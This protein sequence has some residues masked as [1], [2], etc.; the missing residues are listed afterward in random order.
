MSFFPTV[1]KL[2]GSSI[3]K[4]SF[5]AASIRGLMFLRPS[6]GKQG[7]LKIKFYIDLTSPV[8]SEQFKSINCP[9]PLI[10]TTNTI[11]LLSFEPLRKQLFPF[12]Q[13]YTFL[14]KRLYMFL[15]NSGVPVYVKVIYIVLT[16]QKVLNEWTVEVI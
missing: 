5:F 4:L 12:I 14:T 7:G 3:K 15:G 16:L 6:L 1:I 11:N 13:E 2:E 8:E 9:L 10:H